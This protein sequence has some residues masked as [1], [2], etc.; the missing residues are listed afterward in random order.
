MAFAKTRSEQVNGTQMPGNF[1]LN[2][3]F[4]IVWGIANKNKQFFL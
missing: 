4:Y 3:G 1:K 2:N